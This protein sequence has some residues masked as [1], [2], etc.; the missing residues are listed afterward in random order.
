MC[1][2]RNFD[3]CIQHEHVGLNTVYYFYISIP[4]SQINNAEGIHGW[5]QEQRGDHIWDGRVDLAPTPPTKY[6]RPFGVDFWCGAQKLFSQCTSLFF[7][8]RLIVD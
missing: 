3:W 1:T 5:T 4:V 8:D 7:P 6:I 2:D